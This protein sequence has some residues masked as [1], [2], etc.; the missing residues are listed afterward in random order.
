LKRLMMLV[1]M[2]ALVLALAVPA[3]I[4]QVGFG[5]GQGTDDTGSVSL[6][7]AVE[8]S[9]NNSSQC[10]APTQFGNTGNAQ[11]FQGFLQYDSELDDVEFG[12]TAFS[13]EPA[14][15]VACDQKVQ[16]AASASST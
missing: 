4:A 5:A 13:F 16:Q 14:Q 6:E 12:G 10:V 2:L 1:V 15:E 9:G 3:A 7:T 11:N 8:Q